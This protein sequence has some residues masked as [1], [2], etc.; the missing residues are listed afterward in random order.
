MAGIPSV[1]VSGASLG[2][3]KTYTQLYTDW[4]NR[5]AQGAETLAAGQKINASRNSAA[6]LAGAS[7]ALANQ[8]GGNIMG[9]TY[10]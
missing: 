3:G 8:T 2:G 6:S 10:E 1:G 7:Q 5:M 9:F 4:A